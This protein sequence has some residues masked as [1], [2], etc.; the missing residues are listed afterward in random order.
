[1]GISIHYIIKSR[2]KEE[3]KLY[4]L[5]KKERN[6]RGIIVKKRKKELKKKLLPNKTEV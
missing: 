6:K 1:L 4:N 5:I 3:C 2:V